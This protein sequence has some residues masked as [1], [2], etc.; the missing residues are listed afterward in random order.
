MDDLI[1]ELRELI[2]EECDQDIAP[3]ELSLD[4]DLIGGPL[5]LDSLDALQ[6]SL[7]VKAK[8]DFRIDGGPESRK[9]LAS[10][11][12]LADAITAHQTGE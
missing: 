4:E 11:Q 3:E 10:L 2:I 7:A 6:I 1:K 9:I 12:S 5:D 8:Y